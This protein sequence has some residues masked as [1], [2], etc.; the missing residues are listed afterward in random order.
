MIY[1]YKILIFTYFI[2]IMGSTLHAQDLLAYHEPEINLQI[3]NNSGQLTTKVPLASA[4]SAEYTHTTYKIT[5]DTKK[6]NTKLVQKEAVLLLHLTSQK[7]QVYVKARDAIGQQ[8][9]S[10]RYPSMESGFYEIPVLP[11][12][13]QS[14]LY[15]VSLVINQKTYSFQISPTP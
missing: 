5:Q 2:T 6:I 3:K 7:N 15:F 12:A 9:M 11:V 1:A 8:V 13:H 4:K 14:H 10:A